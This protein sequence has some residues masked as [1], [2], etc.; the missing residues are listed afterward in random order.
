MTERERRSALPRGLWELVNESVCIR[1]GILEI[2]GE[3]CAS[4]TDPEEPE[5]CCS[6]CAGDEVTVVPTSQARR[7]VKSVQSAR[8][9]TEAV[10]AA[11]VEWR[12]AKA[13]S[14]PEF[15]SAVFTTAPTVLILPDN[16]LTK[17]SRTAATVKSLGSLAHAVSGEWG[18][19]SVYG[20]EVVDVVQSA[21]L[22][23]VLEKQKI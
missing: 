15:S 5:A 18:N 22:Q 6:K 19:L 13:A 9:I 11:L 23:A 2:F 10:K 1:R 12:E 14:I 3:D 17:I 4:Y 7:P 16:V 8:Y 20:K 21:C